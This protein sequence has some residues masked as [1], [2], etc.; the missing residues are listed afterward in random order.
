MTETY[1]YPK[2]KYTKNMISFLYLLFD[3]GDFVTVKAPE[4]IRL[5]VTVYDR[6]VR[7]GKGFC[8]VAESGRI[9]LKLCNKKTYLSQPH[10]LHHEDLFQKD[11]RSYLENRCLQ[12]SKIRE[13]WFFDDLSWHHVLLGNILAKT[14]GEYLILEFLPIPMMGTASGETHFAHFSNPSIDELFDIQLDFENCEWIQ[15]YASEV[16]E[17]QPIFAEE[18]EW[19]SAELYRNLVGGYLR[20]RFDPAMVSRDV[21]IYSDN[22]KRIS[23]VKGVEKRICGKGAEMHDICHLYLTYSFT[24]YGSQREECIEIPDLTE[25]PDESQLS[26]DEYPDLPFVSGYAKRCADSSIVIAFGRNAK[27]VAEQV[28]GRI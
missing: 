25:Y 13:I 16:L 3:N 7:H 14:E 15:V 10:H 19:G 12:E 17:F 6:L 18:L 27:E 23:T 22:I 11:R 4:V 8:P 26:E 24:G 9:Q 2:R 21:S 5:S 28:C 20:I 1:T